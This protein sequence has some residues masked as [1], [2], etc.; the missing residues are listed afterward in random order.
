[1]S[2]AIM[3][4][5]YSISGCR[6]SHFP[7]L[8]RIQPNK[9]IPINGMTKSPIGAFIS[10]TTLSPTGQSRLL[11]F[12]GTKLQCR[13]F[14]PLLVNNNLAMFEHLL[15]P[16][17]IVLGIATDAG[18]GGQDRLCTSQFIGARHADLANPWGE[19]Y[20]P[21]L[22][23]AGAFSLRCHEWYSHSGMNSSVSILRISDTLLKDLSNTMNPSLSLMSVYNAEIPSHQNTLISPV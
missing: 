6:A 9:T 2:L 15:P 1:M 4:V 18:D 8:Y 14:L 11:L 7:A 16:Y 17:A 5:L 19:G 10:S 12:R 13:D 21:V 23:T 22:P 3:G 20:G